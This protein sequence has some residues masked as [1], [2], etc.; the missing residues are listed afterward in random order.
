MKEYFNDIGNISLLTQEEEIELAKE[1]KKGGPKGKE[2]FDKLVAANLRLVVSIAKD[3]VKNGV[4]LSDLVQEGSIGLMRAAEKFE[5]DKGFK[6]STYASWWIKQSIARFLDDKNAVIRIPIHRQQQIN[7]YKKEI[8]YLS[9]KLGRK[10]TDAEIANNMGWSQEQ[11]DIIRNAGLKTIYMEDSCG[12]GD[13]DCTIADFLEDDKYENAEKVTC[14]KLINYQLEKDMNDF[15]TKKENQVIRMR[16]GF[17]SGAEQT[18]EE[19]GN[20]F[21]VTRE[22]IRQ[23]EKHAIQKL[24]NLYQKRGIEFA[25]CIGEYA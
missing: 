6:F 21:G 18:L 23:I 7:N 25:D 17:D 20:Y 10:P 14:D 5:W 24:R 13:K 15:L 16:F 4:P 22:R 3:Y 8:I 2:A 1:I 9:Q 12:S 11:L 19:V